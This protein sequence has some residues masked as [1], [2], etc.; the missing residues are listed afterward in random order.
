MLLLTGLL[1]V[2]CVCVYMNSHNRHSYY[3]IRHMSRIERHF[4][5]QCCVKMILKPL[6]NPVNKIN[7]FN[8]KAASKHRHQTL[9]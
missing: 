9:S 7:E 2:Q 6:L 8:L 4:F 1:V 3:V 5:F